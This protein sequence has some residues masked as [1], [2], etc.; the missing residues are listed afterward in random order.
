MRKP[1]GKQKKKRFLL[2]L[3]KTVY[4]SADGRGRG[5]GSGAGVF[6]RQKSFDREIRRL[7]TGVRSY[8]C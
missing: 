7:L 3:R 1:H 6:Y 5:H 2:L 8:F 4:R